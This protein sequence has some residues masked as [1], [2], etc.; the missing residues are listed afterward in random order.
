M[1]QSANLNIFV[2]EIKPG[3]PEVKVLNEFYNK[4]NYPGL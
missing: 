1:K 2:Q 4:S 3:K